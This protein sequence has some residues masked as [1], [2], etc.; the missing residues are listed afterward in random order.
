MT[1]AV[2]RTLQ[3]DENSGDREHRHATQVATEISAAPSAYSNVIEGTFRSAL[4][5]ISILGYELRSFVVFRIVDFFVEPDRQTA[6][7][8][9]LRQVGPGG[10]GVPN[11]DLLEQPFGLGV[12]LGGL[13]SRSQRF[14]E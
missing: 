1:P 12:L 5:G 8:G 13:V 9:I 11:D 4:R 14:V 3:I 7:E 6:V 2:A 10:L